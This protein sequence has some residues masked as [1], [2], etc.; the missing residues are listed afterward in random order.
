MRN[1]MITLMFLG[2]FSSGTWATTQQERVSEDPAPTVETTADGQHILHL[3][4]KQQA[5]VD[6]FLK[7]NR[8]LMPTSCNTL[9]V[10]AEECKTE[11]ND[12]V[13]S[14]PKG[15]P[16]QFPYASWGDF[17]HDGALDLVMPF[18]GRTKVNSYGWRRWVVVVFQGTRSGEY[19]PVVALKGTWGVCFDGMVYRPDRKDVEFWCNTMGGNIRWNGSAFVGKLGKG[20]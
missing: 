20:D 10:S 6:S 2:G 9:G 14:A 5:A 18:F 11:Y 8:E 3:T 13:A 4:V 12:W 16:L 19:K 15:E 7:S 17:N 1:R